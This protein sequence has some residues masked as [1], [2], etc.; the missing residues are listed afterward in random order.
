MK[1]SSTDK[2]RFYG[3]CILLFAGLI[4]TYSNHFKNPFHFDDDHTI[5]NNVWIRSV[6]NI[7]KFYADGTTTS[8]LPSNQA[9]RPGLT[10]LTAIDYSIAKKNP[11]NITD[12]S[13]YSYDPGLN[14]FYYHLSIFTCFVLQ[15]ILMFMLFQKIFDETIKHRWNK[16]F[17]LFATALYC[18]H[19]AMAETLNYVIS[20]SD[21]FSTLMVMLALVVYIYY[22]KLRKF[23]IYLIPYI[24]GFFVKEPA[25]MF[26]P[27]LFFY[28]VL[29][30]KKAD[31]SKMFERENLQKILGGFRAV[32]APLSIAVVLVI[33]NKVMQSKTFVPG[34][35]SAWNYFITQPF[36]IVHYFKTFILPSELSADTDWRI[37]T[38]IINIKFF[39]GMMFI[40]GMLWL[41]IRLSRNNI[42]RGISFGIFWFFLALLPTSSF[43]PLSEV[44]NDHRV[45]FPYIGLALA[46]TAV[47]I[48]LLIIKNEKFFLSSTEMKVLTGIFIIIVLGGFAYGTYQRNKV[49]SSG[50]SLWL[51]VTKKSPENGRGLMNYA[52]SQMSKGNYKDAKI[53]FEKALVLTP[54]YS[55]LYI[56]LGVLHS[57][58]GD[59]KK[60]EEYYKSAVSLRTYADQ[61][62]YYYGN[63]LYGQKRYDEAKQMLRNSIANNPANTTSRFVLMALYSDTEDWAS[64]QNLAT[65]T[66]HYMP[67]DAKCLAYIDASKN[68]K[69]KLE[70]AAEAAKKDPSATNYL[71][72]SLSYY[73]AGKYAECVDA[74]KEAIKLKPD[75][76]LAYNNMCSAYNA[77]KMYDKAIEACNKAIA[78]QPDF[79]LAKNN[80]KLALDSKK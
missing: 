66:L 18:F 57:A 12:T 53:Y 59:L 71:N 2:L 16:Y 31:L 42:F 32:L 73:E 33:F 17:A 38:G 72:L 54:N 44:L 69:G 41:A 67:G 7:P 15:A 37:L 8:S 56:N 77:L 14:S 21:G 23:G 62:Y 60:A 74:C 61:S 70:V 13:I 25:L 49:W 28:V 64:L 29:F 22:P 24:F 11:F 30:E 75:Y 9:Y 20:R 79:T 40:V 4:I 68:K 6:K 48:Y 55:L 45:F 78:I 46:F 19:T 58:L 50:E 63:F 65:E 5:V 76:A 51:D 39:M 34:T 36:V 43:I 80:L 47:L 3:L 1:N 26:G 52:L 27:I 35:N 10:T